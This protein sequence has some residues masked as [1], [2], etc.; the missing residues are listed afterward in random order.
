MYGTDSGAVSNARYRLALFHSRKADTFSPGNAKKEQLN[1]EKA[2]CKEAM[3]INIKCFSSAHNEGDS[4]TLL[5]STI[6]VQL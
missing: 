3:R 4:L 1:L 5:L 2:H 6:L